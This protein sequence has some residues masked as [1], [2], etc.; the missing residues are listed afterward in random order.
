MRYAI[1]VR[2]R[3]SAVPLHD[4]DDVEVTEDGRDTVLTCRVADGAA[5]TGVVALFN[6]LGL[7]VKEMHAVPDVE[8][9]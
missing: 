9:F 4:V 1:R 8:T 6:D 2:G 3:L 7:L 5:L